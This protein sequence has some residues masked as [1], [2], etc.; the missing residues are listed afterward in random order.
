M[1]W[2][3]NDPLTTSYYRFQ[4]PDPTTN[5]VIVAPFISY[6]IQRSSAEVQGTFGK[7]YPIFTHALEPIPVDYHCPPM[8][9][10]QMYLID[11]D[12]PFASA[13]N[14]VLNDKFPLV[15]SA[16]VRRYQYFREEQHA[17]QLKIANLQEKEMDCLEKAMCE[18]HEL[19]RSNLLGRLAL[20]E[21]EILDALTYDQ[22]SAGL[23]LRASRSFDGVIAT[24][25]L[26]GTP[27]PWRNADKYPISTARARTFTPAYDHAG[28]PTRGRTFIRKPTDKSAVPLPDRRCSKERN[29]DEVEAALRETADDIEDRLRRQLDAR[30]PKHPLSAHRKCFKCGRMGHIRSQCYNTRSL[31]NTRK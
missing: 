18:L 9:P 11:P 5:R 28:N 19:E 4:I 24:S 8:T 10:D 29:H 31:K 22:E 25:A 16:A 7:G 23:Y 30:R 21:D 1:G 13:V 26:D 3:L 20:Y 15:L 14:R 12:A 6:A 17:A 2:E 27:S